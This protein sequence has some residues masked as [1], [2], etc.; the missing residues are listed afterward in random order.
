MKAKPKRISKNPD[1]STLDRST[2]YDIKKYPEHTS[3]NIPKFRK[4]Y[5]YEYKLPIIFGKLINEP[6]E[7]NLTLVI[8]IYTLLN[9][10]REEI[11]QKYSYLIEIVNEF[12]TI[13]KRITIP[14]NIRYLSN[15][16]A[17]KA[18]LFAL[19]KD[20]NFFVSPH[21]LNLLKHEIIQLK[22]TRTKKLESE[23]DVRRLLFVNGFSKEDI[24]NLI[25]QAKKIINLSIKNKKDEALFELEL[26]K[27]QYGKVATAVVGLLASP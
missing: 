12:D 7:K 15:D 25:A 20:T 24:N 17:T 5:V 26:L 16:E 1:L 11:R 6:H 23:D 2:R 22:D 10:N 9:F 19:K 8:Y 14:E 18:S 27:E 21:S 3:S 13:L 4:I